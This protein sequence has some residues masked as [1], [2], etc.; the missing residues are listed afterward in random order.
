MFLASSFECALPSP[1]QGVRSPDREALTG[2]GVLAQQLCLVVLAQPATE[3][4][5]LG[6]RSA[7][8]VPAEWAQRYFYSEPYF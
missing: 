8:G 6:A 2:I 4:D 7:T 3:Y 5:G 1:T